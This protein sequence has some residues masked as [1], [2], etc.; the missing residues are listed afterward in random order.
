MPAHERSSATLLVA[1]PAS[2][3]GRD[4]LFEALLR[5]WQDAGL[6]VEHLALGRAED[7]V[8]EQRYVDAA[9]GHAPG[10]LVIG[11]FSIGARIAVQVASRVQPLGVLCFGYPFHV[12]GDPRRRPGL[13]ALRGLEA[14]ALV[15]QGSRDPHG[16]REQVRGYD[17]PPS[18]RVVWLDDGNHRFRPRERSGHTAAGHIRSA[19]GAGLGFV[20]TL[21]S[22]GHA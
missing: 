1:F 8:L 6:R 21:L 15:V 11:G 20:E 9:A 13:E 12:R 2:L 3:G 7:A 18:V 4:P 14:P 16:N 10:S 5:H 19:A 22:R 17:L